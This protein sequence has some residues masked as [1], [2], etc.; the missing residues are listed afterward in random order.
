VAAIRAIVADL[1]T[2]IRRKNLNQPDDARHFPFLSGTLVRIGPLE[3]GRARLEPGWR[4]SM[5]IKPA[6]GTGWCEAHHLHLLLAGR[7]GVVMDD[8]ERAEFVPGDVFDLPPGHDA[9]V[10]GDDVVDLVDIGGNAGNFG[11]PAAPGR[12]VATIMMTDIVG[13]TAI[14]E[15]QG[16]R[17]WHQT[18]ADHNRLVRAQLAR[19]GGREV[20]TTGDGFLTTFD[21]AVSAIRCGGAI[22]AAVRDTGLQV[23][24]GI[25]TGEVE[26]QADDVAGL[27]VHAAAR[28]MA[29][30]GASEVLVSSITRSLADASGL[31][32]VPRGAHVL[33]GFSSPIEVFALAE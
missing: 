28:V 2:R 29:L 32:L 16:D 8:G 19:F 24:V 20:D 4:W 22:C 10:V 30:A 23:R 25:H 9:W 11:L 5:S 17:A 12:R 26:V 3:I 27:A 14:A 15:R 6:V 1:M 7:F 33:K 13:S 21:S 31:E 18:L